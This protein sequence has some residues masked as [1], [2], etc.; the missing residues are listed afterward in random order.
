MLLIRVSRPRERYSTVSNA[1]CEV[2]DVARGGGRRRDGPP[3]CLDV[4]DILGCTWDVLIDAGDEINEGHESKSKLGEQGKKDQDE[5]EDEAEAN[6]TTEDKPSAKT[7]GR[8]KWRKRKAHDDDNDDLQNLGRTKKEQAAADAE[9]LSENTS[10]KTPAVSIFQMQKKRFSESPLVIDISVPADVDEMELTDFRAELDINTGTSEEDALQ[11]H[12]RGEEDCG[13][14]AAEIDSTSERTKNSRASDRFV[15]TLADL[16][17]PVCNIRSQSQNINQSLDITKNGIDSKLLPQI[18]SVQAE[19]GLVRSRGTVYESWRYECMMV[20]VK[21]PTD[22]L[23]DHQLMWLCV[24]S[25]S[26]VAT[27]VAHVKETSLIV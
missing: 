16:V 4:A 22:S 20:E 25:N 12:T 18:G 8:Y 6:I 21:G 17:L 10:K 27:F 24:L 9:N 13:C 19:I 1:N 14:I 11:S 23:A 7:K 26:G 3:E 2:D 15:C 5:E